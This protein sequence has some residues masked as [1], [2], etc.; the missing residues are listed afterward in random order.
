M[1]RHPLRS[2]LAAAVALGSAV[3]CTGDIG[4][5]EPPAGPSA[6]ELGV[7]PA[8]LRRLTVAEY[9]ATVSDL[10]LDDTRPAARFL[11][12]DLLTPFDNDFRNQDPSAVLVQGAETLAGDVATRLVADVARRDQV[13]GCAPSSPTDDVCLRSFVS[14]VGRRAYRRALAPAEIDD[15]ALLG[16]TI[17][18]EQNDFHQGV[19]V[20]VRALLQAPQF[21][22]RVEIG[23]PVAGQPGLFALDG[24]EVATRLS[25]LLSGSTPDDALLAAAEAG[26]LA[27]PD[28]RAAHAARILALP[29]ARAH[30]D[31]FHAMWLGYDRLSVAPDL[32]QRMRAETAALLGRVVFDEQ[33]SWLD[34]FTATETYVDDVLAAHYGLPPPGSA[35]PVWAG[36]SGTG[37]QGLLSHGTFLSSASNPGDTSPTKRGLLI[38]DRLLCSPVPPPPPDVPADMPPD[39]GIAECKWDQYAA[40][41][42]KGTCAGCHA[43]MDPIGFGLENYDK[44]GRY[45]AH[46]DGKPQCA[47]SGEGELVG[48]GTFRGPAEL[49]DL[50][51]EG[52]AL[53]ACATRHLLQYAL[54]HEVGPDD[55]SLEQE[56][57]EAF[58]VA[59]HRFDALLIALVRSDAFTYR[60]ELEGM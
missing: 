13:I 38:R 60:L 12:E 37:R 8:G 7:A 54:G 53:E 24:Y 35:A 47:I 2:H 40:H 56:L 46:D 21:L 5:K 29:R 4:S 20:I 32:A 39:P 26:A 33:R 19:D 22:Y 31:R 15:L 52:G 34:L 17:A 9:D 44:E 51:V 6:E 25:Y 55:A 43:Q 49:S 27:S 18:A 36:L 11:P 50:L 45:R 41:R 57:G 1:L 42:E 58:T 3:A 28:D 59:G 30:V 23:E 16:S 14:A 48:A 10:L